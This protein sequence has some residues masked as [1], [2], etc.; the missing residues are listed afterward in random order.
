MN[1]PN[2]PIGDLAEALASVRFTNEDEALRALREMARLCWA[3][4]RVGGPLAPM[5]R[6]MSLCFGL[7][8]IEAKAVS[9]RG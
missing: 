8:V 4:S 9:G 5:L 6:L 7:A 1:I 2:E 3:I